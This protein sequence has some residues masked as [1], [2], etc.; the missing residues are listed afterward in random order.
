M[1]AGVPV[2]AGS[3][4]ELARIVRVAGAAE[5]AERLEHAVG[6]GVSLL[7][8]TIDER[9]IILDQ[10]EDPAEGLAELRGVLVDEHQ[11]RQAGGSQLLTRPAQRS[12]S[13]TASLCSIRRRDLRGLGRAAPRSAGALAPRPRPDP[14]KRSTRSR[15]RSGTR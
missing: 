15:S 11:W 6:D 7:A 12:R 9:A 13:S 1:L 14:L 5:L 8:L 2:D 3:V 4:A 10:L